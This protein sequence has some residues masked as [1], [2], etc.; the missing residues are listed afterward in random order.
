MELET[1]IAQLMQL[2]PDHCDQI[3]LTKEKRAYAKINKLKDVPS[4]VSILKAYQQMLQAWTIQKALWFE[5]L[6]KKRS[7]RS[8]SGIVPIQVL[9]KPFRCPGKC[10]FCPNDATMPKSYINTQP[11]AMRAL[12]NNFDPYKQTYNRLLSLMLTGHATDKIEMIVLWGTRDVYPQSYKTS[13]V[14]WLYDAC[15]HF[16]EFLEQIDIDFSNPKAPRYTTTEGIHI[17]YPKTIQESLVRNEKS[18]HRIIWLTIETRP[19]YVTD[20]NCQYRRS[21]GVTRIEMGIQ[22]LDD[23]VL[24][25]NKRGH[26]TDEIEKAMFKLRQYAFKIS[27]HFMPGLYGSTVEKDLETFKI[28]Y[29]SPSIKPDEI[30]F[31]P[32]AVIPNTELYDLRKAW[33]YHALN[34]DELRY[35][36]KMVKE[37]Y[38]PPYT[39]IKRLARDFDTNEVVAWANT[40]N[41]RQLVVQEME[42]TF[43]DDAVLRSN[44][45]ARLWCMSSD[46]IWNTNLW[47]VSIDTEEELLVRMSW[48]M[49][50]HN[51]PYISSDEK[52]RSYDDR[53]ETFIVGGT[54]DRD[55]MR[56]FVCL[57]TR[58][59]EIR[60]KIIMKNEEWK[61]RNGSLF[62]VVRRYR[63]S[64]GDELFLSYED[65]FWYLAGFARLLLPDSGTTVDVAWLWRFTAVIRELHIYGEMESLK[66]VTSSCETIKKSQHKW[67]WKKLIA[68]AERI[69]QQNNYLRLSIISG[70]GVRGYYQKLS[71]ELEGTYMVK[72]LFL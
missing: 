8:M 21:L 42:K 29:W 33:K 25:M 3:I 72:S 52:E 7:I 26:S 32:T 61:M 38:I 65:S 54:T 58:C 36:T 48:A 2:W 55:A 39:R 70:V 49:L 51:K 27:C 10:I 4:H 68:I 60:N 57:C 46:Q 31:Y 1:M 44:H 59:R 40:P 12:L 6:L 24:D 18:A 22:S 71:Y 30:K 11:W 69:A 14:K 37:Q 5:Q 45:Y 63:S 17:D 62:L 23:T 67:L 50:Q 47:V 15:N 43:R 28:A 34:H 35:I 53:I 20:A 13:F 56:N 41:L 66:R 64:N 9:T 19:E 16:E